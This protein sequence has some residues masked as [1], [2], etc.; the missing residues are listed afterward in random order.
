MALTK[1]RQAGLLA[2]CRIEEPTEEEL[3]T[4]ETLYNA[5]VGYLEEAGVSLPPE[6]TPRRAQYDLC[7]NFMV[8]RD[9]DLRDVTITGTIVADNPAFQR[10][11]TQLKLTEPRGEG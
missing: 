11:I 10:L 3:L 6:G 5:A 7:V 2:Y 8:L 4:L 1:E 9:F